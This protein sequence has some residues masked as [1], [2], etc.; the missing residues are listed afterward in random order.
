MP[1][2]L[3]ILFALLLLIVVCAGYWWYALVFSSPGSGGMRVHFLD[4]GQGDAVL[5]ETPNN[6]QVL[7]DA[8]R[9]ISV[10]TALD[11]LL[12]MHDTEIDVLVMTHPDADHIG[13][14]VPVLRRYGTDTVI[15]SFITSD[16][17]VYRQVNELLEERD[18]VQVHDISAAHTFSLDDVQF[19]ILWPISTDVRE[20]NAASVVLLVTYGDTEILLT[21]DVNAAVEE[22]LIG[23]FADTLRDIDILKAGHHGSK[24]STSSAFLAHVQP[25][26]LVY[27]ASA[28]NRYGH[29][30]DA[31]LERV[32]AY[33]GR[34]RELR[35]YAT[36]KEG[37]ISFCLSQSSYRRCD[38]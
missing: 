16:T 27:S 35:E 10:L 28:G 4:V 22:Y 23:V 21:G 38:G 20:T 9:G 34:G 37:T 32:E 5:I 14:F 30:S 29:P 13:G 1:K 6:R 3:R 24:T 25:E 19:D 11:V 2:H 12:P 33:R 7:I 31:V 17:S 8:G 26:A 18:D 36:A 15:R